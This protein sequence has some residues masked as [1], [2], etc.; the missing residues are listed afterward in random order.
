MKVVIIGSNGLLANSIGKY[1]NEH[2]YWLEVVGLDQPTQHSYNKFTKLDLIN[3]VINYYDILDAD[4]IFYAA[5]A[6]IQANLK[7]SCPLIYSLNV[8]VP[9]QIYNK[10]ESLN[11]KGTFV[12][13]GS[14]FEI[15]DNSE[16]HRF[17]E[18]EIV[19][20]IFNVPNEYCISKRML[21]RFLQSKSQNVHH[22][23]VIFPTIY[24][25]KEAPH[26]IIPYVINSIKNNLTPKFT[27]GEQIRQYLYIDDVPPIL[28]K[29]IIGNVYGLLNIAGINTLSIKNLIYLI[30]EHFQKVVPDNAFGAEERKDVSMINLQLDDTHLNSCLNDIH[31]THIKQ[32]IDKYY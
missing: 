15:G 32:V 5:G 18:N 26:R 19:S 12:S 4:V 8:T 16:N 17:T 29:A 24:G 9:I 3:D 28:F 20:S 6:G 1:C 11:Y 10:L 27:S 23:H 31:Y 7:E 30:Y 2:L 22:L 25:E 21:S 13:Y 14:Y